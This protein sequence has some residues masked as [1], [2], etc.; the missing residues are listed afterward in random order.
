MS[1]ST[2]EQKSGIFNDKEYAGP[3]LLDKIEV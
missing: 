1:S 2:K 3:N